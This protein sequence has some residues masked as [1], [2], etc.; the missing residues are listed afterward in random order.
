MKQ[1]RDSI[2]TVLHIIADFSS[3]IFKMVYSLV[4]LILEFF[5]LYRVKKNLFLY[6]II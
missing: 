3:S 2:H 4:H 6:S 1:F 5:L